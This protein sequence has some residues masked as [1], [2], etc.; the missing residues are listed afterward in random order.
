MSE[1]TTGYTSNVVP[2]NGALKKWN[3]RTDLMTNTRE[4]VK[5]LKNI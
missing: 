5:A 4:R 3:E 1:E 2:L